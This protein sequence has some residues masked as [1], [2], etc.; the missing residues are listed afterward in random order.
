MIIDVVENINAVL[1]DVTLYKP[2]SRDLLL[3]FF[4]TNRSLSIFAD[5]FSVEEAFWSPS[6]LSGGGDADLPLVPSRSCMMNCCLPFLVS[7]ENHLVHY[8]CFLTSAWA[9]AAGSRLDGVQTL[10]N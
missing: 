3:F 9:Q 1:Y 2:K 5:A 7:M 6:A 8:Y 4:M 10:K